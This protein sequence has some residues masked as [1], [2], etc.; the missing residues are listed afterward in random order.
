MSSQMRPVSPLR[1]FVKR[2][3]K[4]KQADSDSDE[5]SKSKR[6][7]MENTNWENKNITWYRNDVIRSDEI[8]SELFI[9]LKVLFSTISL[10]RKHE[11]IY[12]TTN[13]SFIAS[14]DCHSIL[15]KRLNQ[16]HILR[17]R[18]C[19]ENIQS[20]LYMEH[21]LRTKMMKFKILSGSA[22]GFWTYFITAWQVAVF[23]T[24]HA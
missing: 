12:L 15:G 3:A 22:L 6:I 18:W 16:R 21:I 17:R 13:D 14:R 10:P 20:L 8:W 24:R 1:N 23:Q 2:I 7:K 5:D 11:F 4:P 19:H 9:I